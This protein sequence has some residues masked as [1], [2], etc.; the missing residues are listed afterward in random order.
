VR[1]A[2][3]HDGRRIEVEPL[4]QGAALR[5]QHDRS[6]AAETMSAA[7]WV[8]TLKSSFLERSRNHSPGHLLSFDIGGPMTGTDCLLPFKI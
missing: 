4:Q 8:L 5:S 2:V 7:G 3:G 1:F 6:R